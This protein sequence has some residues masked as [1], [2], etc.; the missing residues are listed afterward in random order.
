VQS[1]VFKGKIFKGSRLNPGQ[2]FE[3][4][5]EGPY[6]HVDDTQRVRAWV[7]DVAGPAEAEEPPGG[8]DGDHDGEPNLEAMGDEEDAWDEEAGDKSEL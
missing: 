7:R 8:A 6:G 5:D 2:E 4:L 3:G 1:R